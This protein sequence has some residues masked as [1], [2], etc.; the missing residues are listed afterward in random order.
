MHHPN[1]TLELIRH[2]RDLRFR[3]EQLASVAEAVVEAEVIYVDFTP[4]PEPPK[5]AA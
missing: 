5:L 3:E 4:E 1:R 2:E